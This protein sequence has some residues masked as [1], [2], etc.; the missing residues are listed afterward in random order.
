MV[1]ASCWS[2]FPPSSI[3]YI[4]RRA[5]INHVRSVNIKVFQ[6]FSPHASSRLTIHILLCSSVDGDGKIELL[7][8]DCQLALKVEKADT[9]LL[10]HFRVVLQADRA[11][12]A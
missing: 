6:H 2:L 3:S 12:I 7:E 1:L 8:N 9:V 10:Y 4:E 11:L 5:H